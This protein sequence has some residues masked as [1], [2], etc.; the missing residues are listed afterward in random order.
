MHWRLKSRFCWWIGVL[1]DLLIAPLAMFLPR[2]RRKIVFGAWSGRQYSCNPRYLMEYILGRG[3]FECVWIGE[4][5][6]RDE[7]LKVKGAKFAEKGSLKALWHCLTAGVW[8][9]NVNWRLD[10]AWVPWCR[11]VVLLYLGNGAPDKKTGALQLDGHGKA[12]GGCA[13][14]MAAKKRIVR[15][16]H[17][18]LRDFFYDESAWSSATSPA[19]EKIRLANLPHLLSEDRMIRCGTPR[20]DFMIHN[21]HN[22][23]LRAELRKKYADILGV[24][25]DKRWIIYVPTWR[26]EPQYVFSFANSSSRERYEQLLERTNAILIEKHHPITIER[27]F[28]SGGQ[29]G[30]ITVVSRECSLHIDMQELLLASDLMITDYSSVYYEF[31]LMDR[32]VIH[33]VYDY[34]HFMNVDMGFNFDIRE[35]GGGPFVETEDELLSCLERSYGDLLSMRN[36]KTREHLVYETGHACEGYCQLLERLANGRGK[37]P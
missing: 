22:L 11:R 20:C 14:R 37:R 24:P 31:Y 16:L 25:T 32:P 34:D 5:H 4:R 36:D 9:C 12:V 29:Y 8:A 27:R 26:H 35:Y 21:A 7:V 23:S 1:C 6:L 18:R 10:I 19:G 15:A 13:A 3:G 28:V 33:F 2:N 17:V 30:S